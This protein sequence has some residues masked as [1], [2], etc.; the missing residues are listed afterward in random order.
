MIFSKC[1]GPSDH[2]ERRCEVRHRTY[3]AANLAKKTQNN[4]ATIVNISKSGLGI[5]TGKSFN[6]GDIV[7]VFLTEKRK[8]RISVKIN[9]LACREENGEYFLGT[10]IVGGCEK[11][12]KLY[13]E[14]LHSHRPSVIK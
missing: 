1:A 4:F 7:N 10:K 5:R 9:V 8:N 13:N 12:V 11:H 14:I 6:K 2:A 3:L